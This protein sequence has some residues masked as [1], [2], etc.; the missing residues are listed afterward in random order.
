MPK[1][2]GEFLQGA[3]EGI[4]NKPQSPHCPQCMRTNQRSIVMPAGHVRVRAASIELTRG[5]R[6]TAANAVRHETF[7]WRCSNGHQWSETNIGEIR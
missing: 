6:T 2:I 1:S 7:T 4:H 5:N 3:L